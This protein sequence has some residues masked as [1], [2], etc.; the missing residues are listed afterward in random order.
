MNIYDAPVWYY[1]IGI[2][3]LGG[4][5]PNLFSG[6]ALGAARSKQ[7]TE[8]M[9]FISISNLAY[10]FITMM[11]NS[12]STRIKTSVLYTMTDIGRVTFCIS[13]FFIGM[14]VLTVPIEFLFKVVKVLLGLASPGSTEVGREERDDDKGDDDDEADEEENAGDPEVGEVSQERSP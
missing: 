7:F 12:E 9:L 2:G 5:I 1:A 8:L 11:L 13:S 4:L 6:P 14:I 3:I 10:S